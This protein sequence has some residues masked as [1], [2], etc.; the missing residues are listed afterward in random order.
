MLIVYQHEGSQEHCIEHRKQQEAANHGFIIPSLEALVQDQPSAIEGMEDHRN[1][2]GPLESTEEQE[3]VEFHRGIV[4][5][6]R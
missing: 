2:Q 1:R 6:G 3:S 5:G 4:A